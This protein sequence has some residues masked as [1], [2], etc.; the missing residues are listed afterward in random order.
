LLSVFK[1]NELLRLNSS[2]FKISQ[3]HYEPWYTNNSTAFY[4]EKNSRNEKCYATGYE[5]HTATQF[6]NSDTCCSHSSKMDC[7]Q[8]QS[9]ICT[10]MNWGE[11]EDSLSEYDSLPFTT[12][13]KIKN[14]THVYIR[15]NEKRIYTKNFNATLKAN[16]KMYYK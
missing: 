4:C 3:A 16:N 6:K 1:G 11:C 9:K 13:Y 7:F 8:R 15:L 2:I 14:H 12:K 10:Q 5:N